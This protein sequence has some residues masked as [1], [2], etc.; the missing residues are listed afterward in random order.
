MDRSEL[1]RAGSVAQAVQTE[2]RPEVQRAQSK[3]DFEAEQYLSRHRMRTQSVRRVDQPVKDCSGQNILSSAVASIV[4]S[5][6]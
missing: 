2:K 4:G 1:I 3:G 6:P 5:T